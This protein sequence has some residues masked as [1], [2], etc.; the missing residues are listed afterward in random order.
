M[1]SGADGVHVVSATSRHAV[2]KG[3][4]GRPWLLRLQ[5]PRRPRLVPT[6]SPP[7]SVCTAV[8]V[9]LASSF[10]GVKA[11]G[12][13]AEL[14][15]RGPDLGADN[16]RHG[17]PGHCPWPLA[18][19][20]LLHVV[21]SRRKQGSGLEGSPSKVSPRES[22]VDSQVGEDGLDPTGPLPYRPPWLWP[23]G[24]PPTVGSSFGQGERSSS[25]RTECIWP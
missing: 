22:V 10:I 19:Q 21:G 3:T 17:P 15:P 8:A 2:D 20:Q 18:L 1:R 16:D 14:H 13:V 23:G 6:R 11:D 4:A 25:G 7:P 5:P 24:R 9:R 12:A